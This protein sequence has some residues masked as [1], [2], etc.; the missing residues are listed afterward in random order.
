MNAKAMALAAAKVAGRAW[1][2]LPERLR[3]AFMWALFVLESRAGPP[4]A[5][6]RR[7]FKLKDRLDVAI[8]ERAMAFEGGE[9]PK[10]RLTAYHD[11]FVARIPEGA[12]VLD[13]GCGY[14]AVAR[15]IAR[16]CPSA[17]VVGVDRDAPRLAQARA[18]DN[19]PN[20]GFIEADAAVGLP[21][22][23]F[24]IVVLSNVLEHVQE[25]VGLLRAVIAATGARAILIR[26]PLFERGWE[27]AM[28]R[29]IGANYF[30]DP[31]HCIEHTVAEF[32]SE[33]RAA[34]LRAV[35]KKTLWGEIWA[36]ARPE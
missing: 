4:E 15:S 9:H 24:D 34:G 23:R 20:L 7:L 8:S 1:A 18:A 31:E 12:R 29:E 3:D 11:F 5:G 2:W 32:E 33:L 13:I 35:E 26:V 16:A 36:E 28:R 14:G 10:H 22:G 21:A 30:S 19:P 17:T 25:R 27:M 6:L